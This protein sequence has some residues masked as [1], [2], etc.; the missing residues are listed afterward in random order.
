MKLPAIDELLREFSED[1]ERSSLFANT[2]ANWR[3]GELELGHASTGKA[4]TNS[5]GVAA[6]GQEKPAWGGSSREDKSSSRQS[7]LFWEAAQDALCHQNEE[8]WLQSRLL[9][10]ESIDC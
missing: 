3:A 9:K 8:F 10:R 2:V 7:L 4:E 6:E 5:I 1:S